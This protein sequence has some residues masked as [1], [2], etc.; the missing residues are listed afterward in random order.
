MTSVGEADHKA[1]ASAGGAALTLRLLGGFELRSA[2]HDLPMPQG[3]QRLIALLA[4]EGQPVNRTSA[5]GRLWPETLEERST[6][7]LRSTLWRIRRCAPDLR[8]VDGT[9]Q[10]L[11]LG[12]ELLSDVT[13]MTTL[14]GSLISRRDTLGA[15]DPSLDPPF[16]SLQSLRG[17]LLPG[18]YEDWVLIER[19]R[20]QQL[21]IH[22]L[23]ALARRWAA[24]GRYGEAV[25][26]A[27]SAVQREPLRESA[28]RVLID[29]YLAEGNR[30]D[31]LRQY[32]L[33]ERLLADE[34][35]A[36]PSSAM[37]QLLTDG[38]TP[39]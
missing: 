25:Q 4:L 2:D 14:A 18:W 28:H 29:V 11:W 35:G 16:E 37:R 39:R 3:A 7:N 32:R 10:A 15:V 34:L 33:Y 19:E 31:A 1:V 20:L 30:V 12:P 6:A 9:A 17:T 8:V 36:A 38:M 22:G 5:A 24:A 13:E 21:Q 23:E 27:L 26:A